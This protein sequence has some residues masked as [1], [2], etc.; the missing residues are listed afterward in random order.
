M[1]PPDNPPA[2]HPQDWYLRTLLHLD[3]LAALVNALNV[4]HAAPTEATTRAALARVQQ[5]A[6]RNLA[7]ETTR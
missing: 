1:N 6:Q 7:H 4:F 2:F 3:R 5:I